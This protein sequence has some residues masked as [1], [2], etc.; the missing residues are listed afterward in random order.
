[1]TNSNQDQIIF[2]DDFN[3]DILDTNKW[4]PHYL[5]HWSNLENSAAFYKISDSVLRLHIEKDQNS[6]CPEFDGNN[7][8]SGLQ[9]GHYSG[10]M[11]SPI[12]QHRFRKELEVRS[13]QP[14]LRLFLP[15]YCRLEMR[16]RTKLQSNNLAALWLIGYEDEPDKSGE[17]T[18]FEVFG[19]N[20]GENGTRIG[21]GIKKINDPMLQDEFE[22]SEVLINTEDW[23]TYSMDWRPTGV[24]FYID[25]LLISKTSQS[26]NYPMQL[27]LNFYELAPT[28]QESEKN[29]AW[30]EVDCIRATK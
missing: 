20:V 5:P 17:I 30:F 19:C 7:K 28:E 9:T 29:D 10:E 11:G 14:E 21:R 16:A 15:L 24:L 8:V 1:M 6:W 25:D 27:M 12:G 23:H 2:E 3:Q 4:F 26:P 22:D 13:F 18:L